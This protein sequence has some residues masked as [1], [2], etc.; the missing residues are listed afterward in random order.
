MN[1]SDDGIILGGRRFGEGGL[2]VDVLTSQRGRRAGLVYGGAS[3]RRRAQ[4][5]AGN[6][7]ALAWS[8]R[9]DDHLGRFDVAEARRERAA[10]LLEDASALA[11]VAS[12]TALLRAGLNE[13]DAAGSNLFEATT[14][15]LDEL[16]HPE[17]WPALYVRW[18]LGLLSALGFG[19]DLE[20]CALSGA[21]DGLT[22]VS[23]KTGRAVRGSEAEDYIDRLFR[24]PAFLIDPKAELMPGDIADGLK[25]TGYFL[26]AR[27]FAAIHRGLPPERERLMLRLLSKP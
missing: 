18:E 26:E 22:H 3:R 23:P 10:R 16:E 7:V 5:E 1:W 24:L 21:N 8:G 13:G 17:I 4:Y 19:L 6:T 27:L 12:I 9:L 25:L 14:L 15:L 11:A 20:E 2:I